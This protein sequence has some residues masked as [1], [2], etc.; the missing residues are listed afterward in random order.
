MNSTG[1]VYII[2]T[3]NMVSNGFIGV[4]KKIN[5]KPYT[6]IEATAPVQ[7]ERKYVYLCSN[8]AWFSVKHHIYEI[9]EDVLAIIFNTAGLN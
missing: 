4:R 6:Q 5:L 3:Y 1:A 9:F 8:H 2:Y 7:L